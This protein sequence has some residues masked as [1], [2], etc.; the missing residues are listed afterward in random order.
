MV[1]AITLLILINVNL[2]LH[3]L[4]TRG[5]PLKGIANKLHL[6]L[7]LRGDYTSIVDVVC[8][9]F[10]TAYN[11]RSVNVI[12]AVSLRKLALKLLDINSNP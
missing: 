1:H 8:L 7:T 12:H 11:R 4:C 3:W 5:P 2:Y 6:I 9:Y 10:I